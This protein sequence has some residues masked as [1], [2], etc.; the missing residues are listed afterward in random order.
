MSVDAVPAGHRT[1]RALVGLV[2]AAAVGVGSLAAARADLPRH[3][4]EVGAALVQRVHDAWA[5]GAESGDRP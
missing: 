1:A 3:T 2:L 4:F 5:A